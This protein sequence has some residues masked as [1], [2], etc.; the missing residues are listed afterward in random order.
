MVQNF[1]PANSGARS[2]RR[3]AKAVISGIYIDIFLSGGTYIVSMDSVQDRA[4]AG[5]RLKRIREILGF[6]Q[7]KMAKE[8]WVTP[9]AIAHWEQGKRRMPGSARKWLKLYE[10]AANAIRSQRERGLEMREPYP[11]FFEA[12]KEWKTKRR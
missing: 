11:S 2:R 3:H 4:K 6:S 1:L 9:G 8:L 10:L 5:K 7:A 12:Q